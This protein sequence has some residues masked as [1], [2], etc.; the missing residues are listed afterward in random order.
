[1]SYRV[2][3][4]NSTIPWKRHADQ[5]IS[6]NISTNNYQHDND[7]IVSTIILDNNVTNENNEQATTVNQPPVSISAKTPTKTTTVI[8]KPPTPEK[9][10]P[11][12]IRQ[13][14]R[15]NDFIYD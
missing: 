9:R 15:M 13:P 8:A 11:T 14:K 4:N 7:I 3:I 1:M 12:K 6:S 2:E 5:I 10:Y